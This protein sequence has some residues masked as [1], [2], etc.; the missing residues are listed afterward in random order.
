MKQ[1]GTINVSHFKGIDDHEMYK[2][3]CIVM[4]LGHLLVLFLYNLFHIIFVMA[5][6]NNQLIQFLKF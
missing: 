6:F 5:V 4:S 3:N 2:N 1:I